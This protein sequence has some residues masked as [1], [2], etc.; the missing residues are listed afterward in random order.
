M[1]AIAVSSEAMA[2]AVKIAATA[3]RLRSAGKPSIASEDTFFA[4]VASVDIRQGSPGGRQGVAPHSR[5]VLWMQRRPQ[6][7][8][9]MMR[10]RRVEA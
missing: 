1:L 10:M 8:C 6:T 7:P 5:D 2:S 9:C 4:A 3:H